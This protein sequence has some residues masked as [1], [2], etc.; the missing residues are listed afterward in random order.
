MVNF[1]GLQKLES[2]DSVGV[3]AA[4]SAVFSLPTVAGGG[5]SVARFSDGW[6]V[7]VRISILV[8]GRML[9]WDCTKELGSIRVVLVLGV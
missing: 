6:F 3:L 9:A 4:E 7:R 2:S 1:I 5:F 8:A